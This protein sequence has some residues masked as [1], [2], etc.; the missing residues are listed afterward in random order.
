MSSSRIRII[1]CSKCRDIKRQEN[2]RITLNSLIIENIEH[3]VKRF[4]KSIFVY[5]GLFIEGINK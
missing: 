4:G 1:I 5:D 2:K 3:K